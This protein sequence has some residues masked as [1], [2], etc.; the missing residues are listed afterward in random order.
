MSRLCFGF[1]CALALSV[2]VSLSAADWPQWRGPGRDNK[3][4]D[5]TAPATW[6]KELKQKW[7]VTVGDGVASPIMAG[8]KLYVFT[9]Q[10]GD[11]VV[12][13]LEAETGKEVWTDKYPA[14]EVG[15][16][17]KDFKGPRGTPA[18]AEGK[19]CTFGVGG[20][21]SCY[22]VAT[23]KLAWRNETKGTPAFKTSYSPVIADG[24]CII[25]SGGGGKGGGGKGEVVAYKL[26]TG[27]EAWKWAG[28]PPAYASPVLMTVEGAK[29]V[30]VMTERNAVGLDVTDGR[31]LFKEPFQ[32]ARYGNTVTPIVDGATLILSGQGTG[33]VAAAVEKTADGFAL[34][35]EWKSAQAPHMYNSP[36][37]VEGR[38]Y[39]IAAS[40]KLYCIDAK[41]GKTLWVDSK[42]RGD[43]GC[44]LDAGSCL[45]ALSSD[46]NLLAFK[47]DEK[48]YAE[49]ARYKV[50]DT[51][52]WTVP[53]VAGKRLYVKDKDSVILWTLE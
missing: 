20:T 17:A 3:I 25:H 41:F 22:D 32:A 27:A 5:F 44:V 18:V 1:A 38:I 42:V 8:D 9:R 51:P 34:K 19:L 33:T 21:I 16:P 50:A 13:C 45:L 48:A 35:E 6:P 47:P 53:I 11:E 36:S 37:L 31:L 43:C 2:T 52:T 7:K 10:G 29:M 26:A 28:D 14:V 30:V 4:S 39:G 40:R 24:K 23:G 46:S 49:L 12:R 15:G